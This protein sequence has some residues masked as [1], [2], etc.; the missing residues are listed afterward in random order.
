MKAKIFRHGAMAVKAYDLLSMCLRLVI[1]NR[2]RYK[3]VV[4]GIAFGTAGFIIIQTMGDSV[5]KKMGHNLELLGE[6]TVMKAYWHTEDNLHPGEYS[7]RDIA[8]LRYLPYVMAVA[9]VVS[10]VQIEAR[11]G[12]VEWNPALVGVDHAYWKTQ[13]PVIAHGRLIGPSDVV[14]RKMVCVLGEEVVRFLFQ[15]DNPVGDVIQV[16]NLRFEVIGTL[17]GI[18]STDIKRSV[19]I[20]ITTAQNLFAGLYRIPEIYVRVSDWNQVEW[21]REQV[22]EILKESHQGYEDGIRLLYFPQ[23]LERVKTITSIVKT[24][25]YSALVVTLILGGIGI[26]NVMLAAIQDRTTEI[27]LRKALGAR[28]RVILMQFLTES[29]FISFFAGALGVL[30]GVLSVSILKHLFEVEVDSVTLTLSVIVGLVFTMFLGIL[31]GLY[32]SI[33]ASRMDSV[34]AMRFE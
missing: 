29:V 20:P 19:F 21:V 9:P 16:G 34:A 1:R 31:S 28:E 2:R 11:Y 7:M 18:Q 4:A 30:T 12:T 6:A 26:T 17:G 13:T 8:R 23:R 24:F 25:I 10:L 3:A 33:K 22:L 14:G 27:G 32:P 15:K 5:E